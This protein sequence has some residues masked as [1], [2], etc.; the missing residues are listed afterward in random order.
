MDSFGGPPWAIKDNISF[1]CF[2]YPR[3][4]LNGDLQSHKD[5]EWKGQAKAKEKYKRRQTIQRTKKKS[6]I[7]KIEC[8]RER[9]ARHNS[10][11]T[12]TRAKYQ[13]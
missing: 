4:N 13:F 1:Y 5:R 3:A 12:Q 6:K 8:E 7:K 9:G 11:L 10:Q 2:G